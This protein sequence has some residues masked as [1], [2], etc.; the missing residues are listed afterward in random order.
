M[1]TLFTTEFWYMAPILASFTTLVA[2]GIGSKVGA[3]GVW[4]QIIAW[5]TGAVVSVAAWYLGLV[6]VGNPT[7]LALIALTIVV[8]L[9]SN[10]IY[11]IP[12]I[13]NFIKMLM[14]KKIPVDEDPQQ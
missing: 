3:N 6:N 9:S 13:K 8:G 5:V 1:E 12:F 10:G 4:K 11:D 2:G 14:E 7:W